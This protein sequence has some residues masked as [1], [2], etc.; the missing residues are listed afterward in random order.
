MDC[1]TEI[2]ES[3]TAEVFTGGNKLDDLA[4]LANAAHA[5]CEQAVRSALIHARDC[6]ETLNQAKQIVGHGN[7]LPWLAKHCKFSER[8]AARYMRIAR[9]WDRIMSLVED[10]WRPKR[11]KANSTRV[12]NLGI[13]SLSIREALKLLADPNN[14]NRAE[15]NQNLR[16]AQS[17]PEVPVRVAAAQ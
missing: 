1:I 17:S 5:A 3:D 11:C 2:C 8:Q 4:S 13:E 7:F 16:R 9:S 6:G 15:E 14:E 12:A 10:K